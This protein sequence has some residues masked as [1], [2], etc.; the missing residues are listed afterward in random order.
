MSE[1]NNRRATI[2]ILFFNSRGLVY[3][4]YVTSKT[5]VSKEYYR[6]VLENLR[7]HISQKQPE[8]RQIWILHDDNVR[9]YM[10]HLIDDYLT[11]KGISRLHHP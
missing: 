7:L 10:A 8:C 1:R 4:Y 11:S 5:T 3:Q 2:F 6:D 9:L